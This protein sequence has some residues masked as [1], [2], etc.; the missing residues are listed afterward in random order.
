MKTRTALWGLLATLFLLAACSRE[1]RPSVS[2]VG[3][4]E[5]TLTTTTG[6]SGTEP[7]TAEITALEP[8]EATYAGVFTVGD[9][10]YQVTGCYSGASDEGDVFVFTIPLEALQPTRSPP[11]FY[12]MSWSGSLVGNDYSGYWSFNSEESPYVPAGTFFLKRLP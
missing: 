8:E 12:G 5:G 3:H 4:W 7:F 10:V 2:P 1:P 11:R 9:E 6:G